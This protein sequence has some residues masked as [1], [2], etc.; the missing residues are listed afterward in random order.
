VV[1]VT[2]PSS[3]DSH[4]GA[5][6]HCREL[7]TY[8]GM[9]PPGTRPL[10]WLSPIPLFK[11][12]N[13]VLASWLGDP[14]NEERRAWIATR[15]G[16]GVDPDFTVTRHSGGEA[17]SFLLLGDPGEGD[18]S[19]YSVIP[20]LLA[21]GKETEFMIVMGD[22]VY[23]AGDAQDYENKFYRPY[24]NYHG[25]IYGVPG[26]H[27]WYDDLNGFMRH[28]CDARTKS[29]NRSPSSRAQRVLKNVLWRD[30]PR[31]DEAAVARMRALRPRPQQQAHQPGPYLAIDAGPLLIVG[32]DTG[33]TGTIDRD[34]AK[35]LK[36]VSRASSK[37]KMLVTGKPLYVDG[38]RRPGLIEDSGQTVDDI[39][40]AREYNYLAAIGGDVHNYQ[41]YPVEV[42]EG[43]TIQY[44]VNGGGGAGAQGTHKLARIGFCGVE[45][46]DFRCYPRR[47]DS[48]SIFSQMYERRFGALLGRLF[49]PPDVAAALLEERLGITPTRLCDRNVSITPEARRAFAIVAPRRERLKGPLH[50]YFVQFMDY[51]HPPMFKSF[52]RVDASPEQVLISCFAVTGCREHEEN[53][54]VEDAVRA[55]RQ[56]DGS[57]RWKSEIP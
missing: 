8:A 32:I 30:P 25:P 48:L 41:R 45:E 49:I 55:T 53:A 13:D 6:W 36:R 44:I 33:I 14:T 38:R 56:V 1:R 31:A 4:A 23:P 21:K 9:L 26:N 29:T 19:Q 28:F 43:R 37:P 15:L 35:W 27:D 42:G 22:V 11:S 16:A 54:P 51:N 17:T 10:S 47:A 34:Q 18:A 2:P 40:R 39:V 52:L 20:P 7:G 5:G 50:E 24:M 57:W 3:R 46:G 12:R